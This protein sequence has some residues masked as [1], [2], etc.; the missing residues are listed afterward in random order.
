[1][2]TAPSEPAGLTATGPSPTGAQHALRAG[3]AR[4]VVTEVGG[5]LRSWAIDGE[6]LL[7]TFAPDAPADAFRGKVLVPWPN[8]LR[9]GRYA[10]GGVER[11]TPVT[12]PERSTALH[13]LVLDERFTLVRRS[14]AAV[15]LGHVLRPRPGYPFTLRLEVEYA[16]GDDALTVTLRATN[17][18]PGPAPFG[19]GLHPYLR[20]T[21]GRADDCLLE[22]PAATRV[23]VDERMLPNGPPVPVAGTPED[24]TRARRVGAGR[25]D[26]CFG[27]LHRDAGG[28]ARIR[29]TI[30]G[31]AREITVWLDAAYRFVQ[32]YT[33][34]DVA[35]PARARAGI[36]IEPMTCAPD[37]FNSGDGLLVLA[38][39]ATFTGRCGLEATGLS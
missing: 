22:I 21:G 11:R 25:L 20:A 31:A 29:L 13:G 2:S 5:G 35:D 38:P 16:L 26:T 8:R 36:A 15:T 7:D 32:V 30:P 18:S 17:A 1:L 33:A 12:E 37:A 14:E 39:D 10:F 24:F 19:A 34:D 23:P 4:A 3:R 28:R 6:E 27:D 9:D